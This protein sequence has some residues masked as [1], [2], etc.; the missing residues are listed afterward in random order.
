MTPLLRRKRRAFC[1]AQL[2]EDT[3]LL[4]CQMTSDYVVRLLP[5]ALDSKTCVIKWGSS[6]NICSEFETISH[7]QGR[8]AKIKFFYFAFLR[9]PRLK[10]NENLDF[11]R[12]FNPTSYTELK[13]SLSIPIYFML[14]KRHVW[15]TKKRVHYIPEELLARGNVYA[16]SW[17]KFLQANIKAFS[18]RS[19]LAQEHVS[20]PPLMQTGFVNTEHLSWMGEDL[21]VSRWTH[22]G[23][24]WILICWTQWAEVIRTLLYILGQ[25]VLL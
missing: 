13:R 22:W 19:S 14:I 12:V 10:D 3:T 4:M 15:G 16:M 23:L 7:L 8:G 1:A 17:C 24:D 25:T 18:Y 20:P 5:Q 11:R 9:I 6:K 21:Y 2:T